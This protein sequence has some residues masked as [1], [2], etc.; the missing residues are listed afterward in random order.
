MPCLRAGAASGGV[1]RA[2]CEMEGTLEREDIAGLAGGGTKRIAS[3][4]ASVVGTRR[5]VCEEDIGARRVRVL[6]DALG[7]E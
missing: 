6:M 2:R 3:A 4:C 5:K 1:C 7:V